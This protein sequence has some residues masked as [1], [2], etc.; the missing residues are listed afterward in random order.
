M[1][2]KLRFVNHSNDTNNSEVVIFQK[3][4]FDGSAV[5][6][7]VIRNCGVGDW[8]PF[9]LSELKL[10]IG[11]SLGNISESTNIVESGQ[12]WLVEKSCNRLDNRHPA[13]KNQI[14]VK[15]SL[16]IGSIDVMICRDDKVLSIKKGISPEQ[17]AFFEFKP[18]IHIGIAYRIKEGQVLTPDVISDI[19]T[20]LS[21]LNIYS[22]DIVMSEGGVGPEVKA[23]SF[24]LDNELTENIT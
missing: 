5:A 21:L 23:L 4:E 16:G 9:Q 6:W 8:H 13:N 12:R 14:E 24:K 1:S 11:D 20:E 22:A 17:V 7:K 18:T 19:N 2:I 10:V 3:D 15:N